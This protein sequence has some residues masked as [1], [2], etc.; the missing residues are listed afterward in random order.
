[1]LGLGNMCHVSCHATQ[2]Q[3]PGGLRNAGKEKGGKTQPEHFWA[4]PF[5]ACFGN[6]DIAAGTMLPGMKEAALKQ[7][8]V[9][10]MQ[11]AVA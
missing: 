7:Q 1:M 8:E 4:G 6:D 10:P 2:H 11:P 5:V 3:L 9:T